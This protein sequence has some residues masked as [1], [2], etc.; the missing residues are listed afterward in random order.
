MDFSAWGLGQPDDANNQDCL[1]LDMIGASL[2]GKG[3]WDDGHCFGA[4][5][6]LCQLN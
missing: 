6:P 5:K 3:L 4:L 2:G 1:L